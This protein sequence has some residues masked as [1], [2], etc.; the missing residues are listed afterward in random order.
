[1]SIADLVKVV[2]KAIGPGSAMLLS[3]KPKKIPVISTGVPQVDVALGV[4]GLPKGR[5][6]EIYGPEAG[7]KTTLALHVIAEAQR[8]GYGAAFID[9]E[10][11]LDPKYAKALGVDINNLMLSQPDSGE[12]GLQIAELAVKSGDCGVVVV[13]SV[14]A[15]VPRAELEG[16]IGDAHI[17]LQA[18]LMGQALRKLTPA[19]SNSECILIFINQLRYK[20][21]VMFGSPHTTPGGRAL[22]FFASVRIEVVRIGSETEGA[23]KIKIANKTKITIAKNKVAPPFKVTEATLV[24]GKGFALSH[25]FLPAAIAKGLIKKKGNTF[26][27]NGE[28]LAVGKKK[29][30]EAL[31]EYDQDALIKMLRK[32]KKG[33][34]KKK[35]KKNE[36]N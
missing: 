30:A 11:A 18:R 10:N 15:L 12:I 7:G 13:D 19:V 21:G 17:G 34:G 1:M 4:G 2:E 36:D 24:F 25:N 20:I 33:K 14:A 29:A 26:Y 35:R 8:L 16:E 32:K 22:K 23:D 5:I 6:V 28:K 31:E 27:F 9:A 3:S